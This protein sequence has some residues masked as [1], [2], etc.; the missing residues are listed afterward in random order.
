MCLYFRYLADDIFNRCKVSA[1]MQPLIDYGQSAISI[2][3]KRYTTSLPPPHMGWA[4]TDGTRTRSKYI[5][6]DKVTRAGLTGLRHD[7][8]RTTFSGLDF[9][10]LSS[11]QLSPFTSS[12]PPADSIWINFDM[13]VTCCMD[14]SAEW[15]C[16]KSSDFTALRPPREY[17]GPRS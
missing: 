16:P 1:V 11:F 15:V 13:P 12:P 17:L 2:F 14:S 10:L 7:M 5:A 4:K 9:S 8:A 3:S 6:T